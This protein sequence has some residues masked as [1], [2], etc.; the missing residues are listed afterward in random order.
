[1]KRKLISF[2]LKSISNYPSIKKE[3]RENTEGVSF[4]LLTHAQVISAD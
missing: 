1:M 2:T 3:G 4:K